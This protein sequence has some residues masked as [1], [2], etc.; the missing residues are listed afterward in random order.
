M[1]ADGSRAVIVLALVVFLFTGPV[2]AWISSCR[3]CLSELLS[4][5]GPICP[6]PSSVSKITS[7]PGSIV[8]RGGSSRSQTEFGAELSR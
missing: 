8:R 3:M 7:S 5:S 2:S 4:L 6:V 1:L